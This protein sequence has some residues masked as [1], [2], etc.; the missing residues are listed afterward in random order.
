M[1]G[2]RTAIVAG[3]EGRNTPAAAHVASLALAGRAS[4]ASSLHRAARLATGS[5]HADGLAYPWQ[6][7]PADDARRAPGRARGPLRRRHRQ[8]A[9]VNAIRG[10]LRAAWLSG[11][12][13]RAMLERSLAALKQVRGNAAPGRALSPVEVRK[14]FEAAGGDRP[15]C[16]SSTLTFFLADGAGRAP[17]ELCLQTW[18]LDR[19]YRKAIESVPP[20]SD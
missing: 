8:N 14:L 4:V 12:M 2:D 19:R 9:S 18:D 6:P 20:W 7:A 15:G 11:D 13:D 3:G 1:A 10:A 17:C 5:E 16:D